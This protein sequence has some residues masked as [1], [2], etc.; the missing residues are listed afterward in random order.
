[1]IQEGAKNEGTLGTAYSKKTITVYKDFL[2]E[3]MNIKVNNSLTF[4]Q[5]LIKI[6]FLSDLTLKST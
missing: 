1:M 2:K 4:Q 3:S 6:L 5:N